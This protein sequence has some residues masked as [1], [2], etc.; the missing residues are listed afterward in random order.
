[1]VYL[2]LFCHD[3]KTYGPVAYVKETVRTGGAPGT[4]A[5]IEADPP[6]AGKALNTGE[7]GPLV[8]NNA[9]AF[10]GITL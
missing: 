2:N 7:T 4:V 5:G 6:V 1:M 3:L 8:V 9:V 10:E